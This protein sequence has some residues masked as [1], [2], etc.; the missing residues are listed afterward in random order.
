MAPTIVRF[1]PLKKIMN[2]FHFYFSA[3][4]PLLNFLIKFVSFYLSYS[5]VCLSSIS[6]SF[7]LSLFLSF[8]FSF[9][10]SLYL[11]FILVI[12]V[13]I[14]GLKKL[15]QELKTFSL[16]SNKVDPVWSHPPTPLSQASRSK[17]SKD[18]ISGWAPKKM[19]R[20]KK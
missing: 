16:I 14:I 19:H 4:L 2:N 15:K 6:F 20:I 12:A 1:F 17:S 3:D 8:S 10:L 5:T 7:S 11:P 13:E 18:E 9:S